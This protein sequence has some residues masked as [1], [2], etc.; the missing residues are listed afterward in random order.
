MSYD[1]AQLDN[2]SRLFVEAELKVPGFGGGRF[3][4]TNFPD[5]GPALYKGADGKQWLIV[6]SPQSMANRMERVCWQ[7]GDTDTDRVGSYNDACLGIPY[8]LAVDADKQALTASP[9]E[10]H[11][12]ASPYIWE[13]ALL[14]GPNAGKPFGA[15]TGFLWDEIKMSEQRLVPWKRVAVTLLAIDPACLLHGIWF[16]DGDFAGGK[17]RFTRALSAYIEAE[18]PNPANSGF[19]KRDPVSDR[20]DKDVGQTAA[21]GFGSVIGPRQHF[22]SEKV[23][24][25]FELDLDRLRSYGLSEE[26]VRALAAWAVYKIRRV[27]TDNRDGVGGLRT[28]CKFVAE[29]PKPTAF[30]LTGKKLESFALPEL[31]AELIK[32]LAPLK[33]L[34]QQ[35]GKQVPDED[36]AILR[37][38]WI[39]KIEA[40]AELPTGLTAA[41]FNLSGLESKAVVKPLSKKGKRVQTTGQEAEKL[42]LALTGEWRVD[43][44]E[45][46]RANHPA[47]EGEDKVAKVRKVVEAA[48]ANYQERWRAKAQGGKPEGEQDETKE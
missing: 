12:L 15:K 20:T 44:K 2:I 34:K 24:A 18:K 45:K 25:W 35:D 8:V 33:C 14:D 43:D 21:E 27:L 26:A 46:L 40:V 42:C 41:D 11:R 6:E 16:S 37:V 32:Q 19:Q 23:K 36:K 28:E 31:G 9:L 13:T 38:R 47:K 5:L 29:D 17:V 10:A 4:P 7:D 48:L 3:Q 30:D 1:Y 22:T 39:P